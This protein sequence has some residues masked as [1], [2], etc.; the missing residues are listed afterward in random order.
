MF[1]RTSSDFGRCIYGELKRVSEK[2]Y[3]IAKFKE[4]T[5]RFKDV[6]GIQRLFYETERVTVVKRISNGVDLL[7]S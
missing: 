7:Y 2:L 3:G 5:G 6:L 1:Y 4:V